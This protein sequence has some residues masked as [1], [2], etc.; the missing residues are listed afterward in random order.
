MSEDNAQLPALDHRTRELI[1]SLFETS[2]QAALAARP[3]PPT[4]NDN[5]AAVRISSIEIDA[6]PDYNAAQIRAGAG[7]APKIPARR[8]D[9]LR[10]ISRPQGANED[11][12]VETGDEDDARGPHAFSPAWYKSRR[13]RQIPPR[14]D[15][16]RALTPS[17][18]SRSWPSL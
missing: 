7:G 9:S 17:T 10:D 14:F 11:A 1:A 8:G 6:V 3:A 16:P 2:F 13:G 12:A 5:G 18:P 15:I 4:W